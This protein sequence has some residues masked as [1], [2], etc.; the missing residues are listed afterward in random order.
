[1]A[2][3]CFIFL[4]SFLK[5]DLFTETGIISPDVGCI[6]D[7]Y[8]RSPP[9]PPLGALG[10]GAFGGLGSPSLGKS[11]YY[12]ALGNVCCLKALST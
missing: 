7:P 12:L 1:M 5:S 4:H 9:F 6:T 10:A 8:G 3:G 2:S 11:E